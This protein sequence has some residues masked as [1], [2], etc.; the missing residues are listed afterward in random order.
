[1]TSIDHIS[2]TRREPHIAGAKVVF[3]AGAI[4]VGATA[5]APAANADHRV[6]VLNERAHFMHNCVV[7]PWAHYQPDA[8]R[9]IYYEERRPDPLAPQLVAICDLYGAPN[10]TEPLGRHLSHDERFFWDPS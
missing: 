2:R 8:V 4:A 5:F 6:D 9:G 10:L 1:M 7:D 3:A